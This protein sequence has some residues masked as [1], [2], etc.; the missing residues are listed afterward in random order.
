MPIRKL[1]PV[2]KSKN[3]SGR[4]IT[5]R[6]YEQLAP[7]GFAE[8][9]I[10]KAVEAVIAAWKKG[11]KQGESVDVPFGQLRVVKSRRENRTFVVPPGTTKPVICR[12]YQYPKQIRFYPTR[13]AVERELN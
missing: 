7:L 5:R 10:A 2:G 13:R 4:I 9:K 11:L 12:R 6:V 8:N 3:P 1:R